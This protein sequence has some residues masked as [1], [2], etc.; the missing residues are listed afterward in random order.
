MKASH[1][2]PNTHNKNQM[3]DFK[4]E[5]CTDYDKILTK[6]P[7]TNSNHLEA[8]IPI[9]EPLRQFHNRLA[10]S[11]YRMPSTKD[12]YLFDELAKLHAEHKK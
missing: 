8:Q 12:K 9:Q 1:H 2:Q 4:T 5:P 3:P 6:D 7:Y 11:F 10:F